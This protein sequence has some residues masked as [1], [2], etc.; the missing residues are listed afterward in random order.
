MKYKIIKIIDKVNT[1]MTWDK[2][3]VLYLYMN[4]E[5]RCFCKHK[6]E[7]LWRYKG[8]YY[9]F[10]YKDKV[11]LNIDS[12]NTTDILSL[13]SGE[14]MENLPIGFYGRNSYVLDKYCYGLQVIERNEEERLIKYNC[15]KFDIEEKE[16]IEIHE[17]IYPYEFLLN[18]REYI[19]MLHYDKIF[20]VNFDNNKVIWKYD[21]SALGPFLNDFDVLELPRWD[22]RKLYNIYIHNNQLIVTVSKGVF[23]LSLETGQLLW[24]TD[25]SFDPL[26]LSFINSKGYCRDWENFVSINLFIGEIL[27]QNKYVGFKINGEEIWHVQS[28]GFVI[29]AQKGY[30]M[31]DHKGTSYLLSMNLEDGSVIIETELGEIKN[32][33]HTED[34]RFEGNRLYIRDCASFLYVYE[35]SDEM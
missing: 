13:S 17:S 25:L 15:L 16:V 34:I 23:A 12:N 28:Y 11:F 6:L 33:V 3:I 31:L 32:H 1:L 20:R 21:I 30:F 35:L 7:I 14:L 4:R 2:D 27:L 9:G 10:L 5:F 24:H 19:S 22:K 8:S 26:Y 29:K 18:E